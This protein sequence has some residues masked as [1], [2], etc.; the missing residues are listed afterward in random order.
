MAGTPRAQIASDE[1]PEVR[2]ILAAAT[3]WSADAAD[4]VAKIEEAG[5]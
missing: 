3:Q 4:L 1:L 2:R 5:T